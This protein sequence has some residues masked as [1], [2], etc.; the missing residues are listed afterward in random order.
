MYYS[1]P[2]MVHCGIPPSPLARFYL[3]L[4]SPGD[5]A[6]NTSPSFI[7]LYLNFYVRANTLAKEDRDNI[8]K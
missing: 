7:F 4:S 2:A 3:S 1:L 6:E 8:K 5:A